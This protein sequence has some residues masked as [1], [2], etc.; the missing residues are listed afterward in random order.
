MRDRLEIY[1]QFDGL[2]DAH[3]RA[4]CAARNCSTSKLAALEALQKHDLRCTLVCT[5]DHN[6][7]LHEVGA[8]LRFGLERPI[9]RGVSYQLATYCG[10]HLDPDD[11]ERRA[12]MP[13]LVKALVAQTDGLVAEDDFYPLPCAHPNC[14]M[15][16][17]SIA[18]ATRRCRSTGSST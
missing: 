5:V 4:R 17:T 6:T 14:H 1:L 3:L 10:R 18:A 2:D 15:M 9:V 12:T 13:D 16:A 11:L 7:N 8:V